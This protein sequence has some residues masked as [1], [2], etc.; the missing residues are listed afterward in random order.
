MGRDVVQ[1]KDTDVAVEMIVVEGSVELRE[2]AI[3]I[4]LGVLLRQWHVPLNNEER[5]CQNDAVNLSAVIEDVGYLACLS[6]GSIGI[7]YMRIATSSV[8]MREDQVA[9]CYLF[10]VLRA[11]WEHRLLRNEPFEDRGEGGRLGFVDSVQESTVDC[12]R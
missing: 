1:M 7:E 12:R 11:V 6:H 9:P 8:A 2:N 5:L 10:D 4:L 3:W